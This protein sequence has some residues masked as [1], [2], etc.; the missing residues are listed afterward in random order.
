MGR[1]LALAFRLLWRSSIT[2]AALFTLREHTMR[3]KETLSLISARVIFSDRI[4]GASIKI[5]GDLIKSVRLV[6]LAQIS[7]DV[8]LPLAAILTTQT[9][10]CYKERTVGNGKGLSIFDRSVQAERA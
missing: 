4:I 3:L 6:V 8:C 2:V 10:N 1:K 9:L 5:P 7:Y